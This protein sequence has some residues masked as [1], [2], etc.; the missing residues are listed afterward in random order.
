[1]PAAVTN[2][3]VAGTK[4]GCTLN[5]YADDS[6][7]PASGG[8]GSLGNL[9]RIMGLLDATPACYNILADSWDP[10]DTETW[11]AS[12]YA[13][14]DATPAP[15]ISFLRSLA[16]G[17]FADADAINTAGAGAPDDFIEGS[18]GAM[19]NGIPNDSNLSLDKF[20]EDNYTDNL[21]IVT[22]ETVDDSAMK[23][24]STSV[25]HYYP[26]T[27]RT[28]AKCN[29]VSRALCDSAYELNWTQLVNGAVGSHL[30]L[31]L[32]PLCVVQFYE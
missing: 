8:V 20:S 27:Y 5:D 17:L 13:F 26:A 12:P 23:I 16:W 29:A 10:G 22:D 32:I 24:E 14:A 30:V 2:C 6:D 1:M 4:F 9:T 25:A 28:A 3:N 19:A 31:L 18:A 15:S 11:Q 21:F 7:Q